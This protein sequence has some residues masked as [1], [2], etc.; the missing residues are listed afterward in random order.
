MHYIEESLLEG[1]RLNDSDTL[2][3][4]YK[5]FYPSIRNFVILNSGTEDDAKDTF[6]ESIIVIY[7]KIKQEKSFTISCSF[8]TYLYSISKNLW[9]K[10]LERRKTEQEKIKNTEEFESAD[11]EIDEPVSSNQDDRFKLYQTHYLSLSKDCQQVLRLFME[12]V[13][14]KEIAQIMG[15]ASEKYA[16][17]R[18]YQ[19]KEILVKRIKSDPYFKTPE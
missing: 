3:Y 9:L 12:K 7:R 2:E 1:I 11:C 18:K 14:L 17:K 19:C 13:P 10:E 6:Q 15:Y 5:K 4:I 8:K 16:K